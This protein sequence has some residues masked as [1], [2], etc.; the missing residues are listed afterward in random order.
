[1]LRGHSSLR[2]DRRATYK[3]RTIDSHELRTLKLATTRILVSKLATARVFSYPPT[4]PNP[5]SAPLLSSRDLSVP[6]ISSDKGGGT[7]PTAC[8]RP[9]THK[10]G[11][12]DGIDRL[13][14]FGFLISLYSSGFHSLI[15]VII[16]MYLFGFEKL[17]TLSSQPTFQRFLPVLHSRHEYHSHHNIHTNTDHLNSDCIS[18]NSHFRQQEILINR[19]RAPPKE[20]F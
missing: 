19:N 13:D 11:L 14:S 18:S 3:Y 8:L 4:T 7:S 5:L 1:M 9:W 15:L 6:T 17:D 12:I 16:S 20:F 2:T 10:R